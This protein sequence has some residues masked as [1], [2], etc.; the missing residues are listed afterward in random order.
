MTI[1]TVT[2]ICSPQ[3][4][5]CAASERFLNIDGSDPNHISIRFDSLFTFEPIDIITSSY[6]AGCPPILL[7]KPGRPLPTASPRTPTPHL[8]SLLSIAAYTIRLYSRLIA[9]P[10]RFWIMYTVISFSRGSTKKI[11]DAAPSQ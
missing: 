7:P 2:K 6:S 11:E 10:R 8:S 1:V 4:V 5:I 9:T 3:I